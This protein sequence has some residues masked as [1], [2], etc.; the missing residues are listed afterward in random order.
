MVARKN[1]PESEGEAG[2]R[3]IVSCNTRSGIVLG[4]ASFMG[5][6]EGRVLGKGDKGHPS[7]VH[8]R[9][10]FGAPHPLPGSEWFEAKDKLDQPCEANE[11]AG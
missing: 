4:F 7:P 11:W 2:G 6:Q 5:M 10:F 1:G 9:F 3:C 8:P